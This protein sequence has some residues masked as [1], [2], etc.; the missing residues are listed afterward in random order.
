MIAKAVKGRG[1]RGVLN[2]DLNEEKGEMLETNMAGQN[3]RELAQEFGEI[4]KLRPNLNK[5]VLH[6]SLS[7]AIGDE[8]SNEQWREIG[9]TYLKGMDL[10][11]NQFVMTRHT[12]TDH[13]HIHIVAN[14]IKFSGEV[15]SDSQDYKRQEVI[16]RQIERDYGLQQVAPSKDADRNAPTKNEIERSLRTGEPSTRQQLQQ[17]CDGAAIN[18][19]SFTEYAERLDAAGVELIPVAQLAGEKLSGISYRLD[20]ETMKG[21]D[22]GKGYSPAGLAKKGITYEKSRDFEAVSRNIE[23][24]ANG[25]TRA[26]DRDFTTSQ[27]PERG[28]PSGDDRTISSST[29]GI[30]DRD[31]ANPERHRHEDQRTERPLE[32]GGNRNTESGAAVDLDTLPFGDANRDRNGSGSAYTRVLALLNPEPAPEPIGRGNSSEAIETDT[33]QTAIAEQAE[34][35]RLEQEER[36]RFNFEAAR[37]RQAQAEIDKAAERAKAEFIALPLEQRERIARQTLNNLVAQFLEMWRK[38]EAVKPLK[39]AEAKRAQLLILNANEPSALGSL[40]KTKK[41]EQWEYDR[42]HAA[43]ELRLLKEKAEE[44]INGKS[45]SEPKWDEAEQKARGVLREKHPEL[46]QVLTDKSAREKNERQ[47]RQQ[48]RDAQKQAQPQR[49]KGG[50]EHD[51]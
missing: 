43:Y 3:A 30:D 17:L 10:D 51:R 16:M 23:R 9:R 31:T 29:G 39:D 8:L 1:F 38:T 18:C 47:K 21:S 36:E 7:A 12:D 22:L 34:K 41:R 40:I 48:E 49:G 15:T 32:K 11:N 13:D 33:R 37:Q 6:V 5:A 14:R 19:K 45:R 27:T 44:I 20:G 26:T 24:E 42:L 28:R 50:Q 35:D 2:Y 46:D 25:T 4:R